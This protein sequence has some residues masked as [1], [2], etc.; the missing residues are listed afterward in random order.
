MS[1][2]IYQICNVVI[3]KRNVNLVYLTFQFSIQKVL[4]SYLT[5]EAGHVVLYFTGIV[6]QDNLLVLPSMCYGMNV[7]Q[8]KYLIFVLFSIIFFYVF[9]YKP[10]GIHVKFPVIENITS[11]I[12]FPK[13]FA[14][15]FHI[16][17]HFS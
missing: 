5:E 13:E 8:L 9:E 10:R 3:I 15:T 2:H 12:Y 4:F 6:L 1:Q 16:N 17:N 7:F 14:H 11:Q